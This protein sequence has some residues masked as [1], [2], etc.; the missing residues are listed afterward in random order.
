M[1]TTSAPE[2]R[3]RAMGIM[4]M[5]IGTLPFGMIGLGL[6]AQATSLAPAVMVRV[7]A[8]VAALGAWA[9]VYPE[10]RALR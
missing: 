9:L 2:M 5:A 7:L 6:V 8:G 4:S 10:V 1:M 3:G